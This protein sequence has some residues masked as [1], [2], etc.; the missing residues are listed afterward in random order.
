M[1]I[2]TY[3]SLVTTSDQSN[4]V[5]KEFF[6]DN[7]LVERCGFTIIYY[8]VVKCVLNV[9]LNGSRYTVLHFL[10]TRLHIH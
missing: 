7:P 1:I 6:K 4:D 2:A 3:P 5:L 10:L 8:A 9:K